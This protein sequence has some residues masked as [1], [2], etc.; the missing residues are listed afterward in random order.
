MNCSNCNELITETN[1]KV[2][3]YT[4]Q[5]N[6]GYLITHKIHLQ[7]TTHDLDDYTLAK[8]Y[9]QVCFHDVESWNMT[10]KAYIIN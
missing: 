3:E 7:Y 1:K 2:D 6:K 5:G 10:N 9:C 4:T 8:T